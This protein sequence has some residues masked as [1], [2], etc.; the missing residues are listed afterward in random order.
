MLGFG[1]LDHPYQG[2]FGLL[3]SV[4]LFYFLKAAWL[5]LLFLSDLPSLTLLPINIF[6]LL[7]P[8]Y[9]KTGHWQITAKK[10]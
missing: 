5:L 4:S 10:N 6:K 1:Q 9:L 2:V 8:T 7:L 3:C